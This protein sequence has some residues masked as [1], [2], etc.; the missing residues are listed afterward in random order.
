MKAFSPHVVSGGA[1]G[2][3]ARRAQT[4]CEVFFGGWLT[5]ISPPREALGQFGSVFISIYAALS[6]L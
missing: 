1:Y 6:C 5:S 4:T 2:D 3:V